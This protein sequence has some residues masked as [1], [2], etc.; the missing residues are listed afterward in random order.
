[1]ALDE[2]QRFESEQFGRLGAT[3][4]MHEGMRAFLDKRPPQF[5]GR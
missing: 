5:Q 2:G 4:D 3:E 1:V